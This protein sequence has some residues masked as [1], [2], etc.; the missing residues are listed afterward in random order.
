VLLSPSSV[1][2]VILTRQS[3]VWVLFIL[4]AVLSAEA[5]SPAEELAALKAE[6]KKRDEAAMRPVND[7]YA[8]ELVKRE[9]AFLNARKRDAALAMAKERI[10]LLLCSGVEW[11]WETET[12]PKEM[13]VFRP[14][15]TGDHHN[16]PFRWE[17]VP[18]G[19]KLT[20]GKGGGSCTLS[21]DEKELKLSG[22]SYGGRLKVVCHANPHPNARPH[23]YPACPLRAP[24]R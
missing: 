14:D 1:P 18:D 11:T 19:I 5:A 12:Y 22:L 15:G 21:V 17:V 7:W 16:G 4:C 10:V 8:L 24:F 3:L 20:H 6:Y 23:H 2:L 13:I 9:K